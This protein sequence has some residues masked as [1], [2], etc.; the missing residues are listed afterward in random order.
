MKSMKDWVACFALMLVAGCASNER[1]SAVPAG[2]AL[3]AQV[4]GFDGVRYITALD[5]ESFVADGMAAGERR[6]AYLGNEAA[7]K[8][9][10]YLAISGGGDFGAYGAGLLVGWSD[11]G[12]RP[13]FDVVTGVSTGALMSPF[14][15]LGPD[16][17]QELREVYTTIT[18]DNI[19]EP[20]VNLFGADGVANTTPLKELIAK[21]LDEEMMAELAVAY[22]QGRWLMVATT[23]FDSMRSVVWNITKIA[24]AG[25]PEALDLIHR[26]LVAS[27][28]IPAAFSPVMFDVEVDGKQYQEMHVDGGVVAQVFLV[29]TSLDVGRISREFSTN[30]QRNLYI[31]RNFKVDPAWDNVERDLLDVATRAIESSLQIQGIGDLYVMYLSAQ[32]DEMDYNLAY[33]PG[34]FEAERPEP[35]DQAFMTALFE[36]GYQDALQGYQWHTTPPGFNPGTEAAA[37]A[38]TN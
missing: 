22:E 27:A 23:N 2:R 33:I 21:Y 4:P 20:N 28:S 34:D 38:T 5:T 15:F 36:R 9:V 35:F 11:A 14:A 18:Q 10:N 32:R 8:A 26:V 7:E 16:Y 12:T 13:V 37:T 30:R 17:D 3:D 31:I 1:L 25:T 6:R 29:P 24:Q 19:F